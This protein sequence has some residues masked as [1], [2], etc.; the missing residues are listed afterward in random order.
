MTWLIKS[1]AK[2]WHPARGWVLNPNEAQQHDNNL[3]PL[4]RLAEW[5]EVK[6]YNHMFCVAFECISLGEDGMDVTPEM[7]RRA[8]LQRIINLDEDNAWLEAVG[9]PD[10]TYEMDDN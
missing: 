5:V 2:Y 7:L 8:L 10:D 4:P 1:G 3:G 6:R 9:C